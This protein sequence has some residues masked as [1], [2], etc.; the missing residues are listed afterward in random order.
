[1]CFSM[2]CFTAA[3]LRFLQKNLK[4]R[5]LDDWPGTNHQIQAFQDISLK[6]LIS[7]NPRS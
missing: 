3:S 2:E 6:F 1:M 7:Q 4:I 5:V